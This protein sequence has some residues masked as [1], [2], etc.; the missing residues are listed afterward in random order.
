MF[1][2]NAQTLTIIFACVNL[3]GKFQ[4]CLASNNPP[5][6]KHELC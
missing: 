6:E 2:K 3:F 5:H 1:A 4:P